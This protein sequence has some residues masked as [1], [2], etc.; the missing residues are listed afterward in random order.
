MLERENITVVRSGAIVRSDGNYTY[1]N[2]E[3]S[4]SYVQFNSSMLPEGMSLDNILQLFEFLSPEY[5]ILHGSSVSKIRYSLEGMSD[6]D[7]ICVTPKAAFWSLT[8]LY[9]SFH[10]QNT[11]LEVPLDISILTNSELY[12]VIYGDTSLSVSM[13]KGFTILYR[14]DGHA[15]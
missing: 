4:D 15:K 9:S 11:R 7:L 5:I 8:E 12:S 13:K 10:E 14:R 6:L 1:R 2:I 3:R